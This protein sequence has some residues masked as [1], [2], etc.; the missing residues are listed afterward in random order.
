MRSS[1]SGH[2]ELQKAKQTSC[3]RLPT[4]TGFASRENI[5]R[6]GGSVSIPTGAQVPRTS[7]GVQ[8]LW[9]ELTNRCNLQ[10]VH[11]YAESSPFTGDDDLLAPGDYH[12][13]LANAA[14]LGCKQVQFIGGEP[15]LNRQLPEFICH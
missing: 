11:C 3:A 12:D 14:E 1:L 15:T 4:L 13:I 9:L 6:K 5:C 2:W 7:E 10:C 8:F